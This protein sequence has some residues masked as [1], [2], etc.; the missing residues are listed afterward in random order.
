MDRS[1]IWSM[2]ADTIKAF[3]PVY[4]LALQAV[5]RASGIEKE[6][7]ILFHVRGSEPEPFTS[8]RLLRLWPYTSEQ[9]RINSLQVL[10]NK[11]F[12]TST[13]DHYYRLTAQGY[14]ASDHIIRMVQR[15]LGKSRLMN[16]VDSKYLASLLWRLVQAVHHI[17]EP[18]DKLAFRSN[19]WTDLGVNAP[20]ITRIDQ[21]L[22]DLGR[23]RDDCHFE[24]WQQH[25]IEGYIWDALTAVW[26]GEAFTASALATTLAYRGIST[27]TYV[28]ALDRLIELGWVE[29]DGKPGLV[30]I[31]HEGC[32]IRQQAESRTNTLFFA[33]WSVLSSAEIT[34]MQDILTHLLTT[35]KQI[36]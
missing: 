7:I 32:I 24:A 19:R 16:S 9:T 11:D 5:L 33:P 20:P 27:E 23:F 31:T 36:R 35:L 15:E 8:A 1:E 34:D 29:N 30:R 18:S 25:Q 21:Y 28:T 2:G 26:R 17:N 10:L 22:T 12:I 13:D 4:R 14:R 3:F 6:W